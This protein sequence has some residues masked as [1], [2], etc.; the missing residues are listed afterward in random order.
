M[1]FP[2]IFLGCKGEAENLGKVLFLSQF[3]SFALLFPLFPFSPLHFNLYLFF[4][5]LQRGT[6]NL[7]NQKNRRERGKGRSKTGKENESKKNLRFPIPLC[8]PGKNNE[9][10]RTKERKGKGKR[11]RR[12]ERGN[13]ESYFSSVL[14]RFCLFFSPFRKKTIFL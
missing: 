8:N 2:P 13:E 11:K 6:G 9:N 12:E 14:Y 4:P 1:F 7:L 5:G 3:S 10:P